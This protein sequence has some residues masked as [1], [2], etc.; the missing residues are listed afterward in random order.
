MSK[1]TGIHSNGPTDTAGNT[2]HEFKTSETVPGAPTKKC[3]Q[4]A[5]GMYPN[6]DTRCLISRRHSSRF[7]RFGH[8][9]LNR[10][11]QA[12]K[13]TFVIKAGDENIR[14]A[15]NYVPWHLLPMEP[16]QQQP[17]FLYPS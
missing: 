11:P 15:T 17:Q 3:R 12:D 8:D 4:T 9:I 16:S 10:P 14:T 5:T 13:N 1:G 7:C 2:G 6:P